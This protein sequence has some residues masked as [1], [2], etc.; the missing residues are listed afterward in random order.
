MGKKISVS[1]FDFNYA[2]IQ[3]AKDHMITPSNDRYSLLS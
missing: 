3:T 2:G 1:Q